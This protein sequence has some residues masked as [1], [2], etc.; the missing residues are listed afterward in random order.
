MISFSAVNSCEAK[1][2]F[3]LLRSSHPTSDTNITAAGLE[4]LEVLTKLIQVDTSNT[5]CTEAE[6][7]QLEELL[8]RNRRNR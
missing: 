7:S 8:A 6:L 1:S 5:K 3:L 2:M 4:H